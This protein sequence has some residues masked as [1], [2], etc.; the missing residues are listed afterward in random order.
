MIATTEVARA[1]QGSWRLARFDPSGMNFFG[2][3][4]DDFWKSFWAAVFIAPAH[5]LLYAIAYDTFG[6]AASASRYFSFHAVAYVI[7]WTAYPLVMFYLTRFMGRAETYLHYMVAYNWSHILQM[8]VVLPFAI[9]SI[10]GSL[11]DGTMPAVSGWWPLLLISN[12][13]VLVYVGF[14][15]K[16][17]L[18]IG[19]LAATG[20]VILDFALGR[21]ILGTTD[22]LIGTG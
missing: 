1:L 7:G 6:V 18:K 14:I 13:Y 11:P 4:V 8:A 15:A 22:S 3:T 10:P 16:A 17:G 2:D 9:L 12:L 19:G 20:L 21:F 5:F